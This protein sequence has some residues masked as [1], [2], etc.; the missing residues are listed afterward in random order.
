MAVDAVLRAEGAERKEQLEAWVADKKQPS[1]YATKLQQIDN[2]VMVPPS[3]WQCAKCDKTDNLWLNL[4]DG[5]I[6]CGRS[7]WDGTGGNNHAIEHYKVT[8]YPLAI[9]LGTITA[10]LDAAGNATLELELAKDF[11]I[12]FAICRICFHTF[13]ILHK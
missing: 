13:L 7:N 4:T 12:L 9:K 10:D 1:R 8:G 3:G 6:L 5:M 11:R 2:A